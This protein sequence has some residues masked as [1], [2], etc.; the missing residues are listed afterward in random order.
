MPRTISPVKVAFCASLLMS[1]TSEAQEAA[2]PQQAPGVQ[3]VP[4]PQTLPP[5][6]VKKAPVSAKPKRRAVIQKRKKEP[7][8]PPVERAQTPPPFTTV[9]AGPAGPSDEGVSYSANRTPTDMTKVGSSVEIV[10][11]QQIEAQARPFV[12]DY[13]DQLPGVTTSQSGPAGSLTTLNIRGANQNYVKVLIDGIDISD[14]SGTQTAPAIEHLMTGD[15]GRIEVVKGSQSTLYG[16]DAVGGI[17]TI[18]SKDVPLGVST[19]GLFEAGSYNTQRGLATMGYG[20]ADGFARFTFQGIH[21]DGFSAADERYGN[22]E[23]DGYSNARASGSGEYILSDAVKV[24]ASGWVLH[25]NL[26]YDDGA[27]PEGYLGDSNARVITEQEAGRTGVEIKG[28]N[29]AFVN[30]FAVQGMENDRT[31]TGGA[32]YTG[33]PSTFYGD[34]VKGEY[35]GTLKAN[36]WLSFV[37]GADYEEDGAKTETLVERRTVDLASGFGQV[38]VQP[39]K[40]LTLTAGG[41][42]D[43]HS[44]FGDYL[45]YR[46]TGA[47]YIEASETKFRASNGT[48]FRAPSLFELYAPFYGNTSLQPEQ[49]FSWDAGVDQFFF[50]G[51]Y[52]L[53]ATYFE[54]DTTDEIEFVTDA[55]HP[56]GGYSQIPGTTH[57]KGVELAANVPVN[58]WLSFYAAYTYTDARTDAGVRLFRIPYNAFAFNVN[59]LFFD[60]V[61][62]TVSTRVAID[63]VDV[64][65]NQNTYAS[66]T[67][68]LEDYMLVNAK[69][70][71]DITPA[72][73]AYVRGENL[74]N[75]KYETVFGYGTP[76]I[77]GYAGLTFKVGG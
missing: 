75:E 5:V 23:S 18:L 6:V 30:T 4:A 2:Q 21:T 55:T 19:S 3:A 69:L 45:T 12:R 28:L 14:P 57:R 42:D 32:W 26:R 77:S 74:L 25:A 29:G 73:T 56:I 11:G 67:V 24:F 46:V 41:R 10:T 68:P 53:S 37:I 47:Y 60:C 40:N 8:P 39:L 36:D 48:G 35:L 58:D 51:R 33:T 22:T 62:A 65:F 63:T 64:F 31:I 7:A 70:S 76:G 27:T 20:S 9:T 1:A 50:N 17:I 72:I 38:Q 52:R 61:K 44:T 34:R 71:Y 43:D 13:L 59:V 66:K 54:L 16:G 15:V 49:S